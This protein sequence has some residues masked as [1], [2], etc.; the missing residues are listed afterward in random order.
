MAILYLILSIVFNSVANIMFK[1][2]SGMPS[3][4]FPK[5][6]LFLG[7]LFLGAVNTFFF[8][9]SLESLKLSIGYPVFAAGS[10]LLIA[11][12]S[13]FVFKEELNLTK[14]AGMVVIVV[15]IFLVSQK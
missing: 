13:L 15:G 10:V 1:S 6:S 5:V 9:R 3:F 2:A 11:L 8:I 7:G 12:A 4:D 14:I